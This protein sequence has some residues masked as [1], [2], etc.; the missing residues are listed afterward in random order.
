MCCAAVG[1]QQYFSS[2]SRADIGIKQFEPAVENYL[3]HSCRL[4]EVS[5]NA[6]VSSLLAL[7]W[8][9]SFCLPDNEHYKLLRPISITASE[10]RETVF[11]FLNPATGLLASV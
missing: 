1:E 6:N 5:V 7:E 9:W 11:S 3:G 2:Q 4:I 10:K 8:P